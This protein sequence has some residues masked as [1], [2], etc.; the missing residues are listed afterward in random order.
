MRFDYVTSSTG[1]RLGSWPADGTVITCEGCGAKKD[2]PRGEA[3]PNWYLEIRFPYLQTSIAGD[4]CGEC[5]ERLSFAGAVRALA[6]KMSDEIRASILE[7][8]E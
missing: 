3:S 4:L 8:L 5:R 2:V 1:E 6:E 7:V